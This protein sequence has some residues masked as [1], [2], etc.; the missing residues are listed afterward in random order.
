LWK[1]NFSAKFL[2]QK[3][4]LSCSKIGFAIWTYEFLVAG[5]FSFK[6]LQFASF[7]K[8]SC[9]KFS[10]HLLYLHALCNFI[11]IDKNEFKIST[12]NWKIIVF[13]GNHT[14]FYFTKSK[15]DSISPF[16]HISPTHSLSL[17]ARADAED[18]TD[19]ERPRSASNCRIFP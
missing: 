13:I 15:I 3:P 17:I 16:S 1:Q 5:I 7:Q 19:V 14:H 11:N 9:N 4:N 2:P 10:M 8:F 18:E 12:M 6:V